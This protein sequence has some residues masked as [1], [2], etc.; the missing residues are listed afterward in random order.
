MEMGTTATL[1]LRRGL[2]VVLALA[3]LSGCTDRLAVDAPLVDPNLPVDATAEDLGEHYEGCLEREGF[4]PGGA[5]VLVDGAGAP[6]WVKTGREVPAEL[7]V[8]CFIEI[9][10]IA[11]E[12]TSWGR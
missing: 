7:H 4:D 1:E 5:Q 11:A 6:W 3:G 9:G 2:F 8:P 12:S 10:G